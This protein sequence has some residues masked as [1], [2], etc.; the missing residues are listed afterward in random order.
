MNIANEHID[1]VAPPVGNGRKS[2]RVG[3]EVGLIGDGLPCCWVGIEIVV[4]VEPI[5]IIALQNV[6]DDHTGVLTIDFQSGIEDEQVAILE[7]A[8]G[9]GGSHM[10]GSYFL[11]ACRLCPI[12][13]DPRMTFHSTTMAFIDHPCQRIPSVSRS[14][15]LLTCE[16]AAPR[17]KV[18]T[19]ERIA[20]GTNLKENGIDASSMK[21]VELFGKHASQ[22]LGRLPQILSVD[23]LDPCTT[24]LALGSCLSAHKQDAQRQD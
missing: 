10:I 1:I 4:H 9:M 24:E 19:I 8:F 17:F 18:G 13:I 15:A 23:T 20:F 22:L 14:L 5:Y 6:L 3:T 7:Q 2:T 11:G 12:R 16:I 21:H